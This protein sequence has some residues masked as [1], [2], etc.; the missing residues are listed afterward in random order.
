MGGFWRTAGYAALSGLCLAAFMHGAGGG[1]FKY[2]FSLLALVVAIRFF[3]INDGTG[4]RIAFVA[5]AV[6]FSF[7]FAMVYS[8]FAV[9]YGWPLDP[10]IRG[11]QPA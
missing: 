2:V 1:V 4:I 10:A 3:R 9:A 8:V 11:E 6:V 5:S 7:V